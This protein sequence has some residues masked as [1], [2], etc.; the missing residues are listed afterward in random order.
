MATEGERL[1]QSFGAMMKS[2]FLT[3]QL[4]IPEPGPLKMTIVIS[5]SHNGVGS[6]SHMLVSNHRLILRLRSAPCIVLGNKLATCVDRQG[7]SDLFPMTHKVKGHI[8]KN[9]DI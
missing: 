9:H 7:W 5:Q 2:L 6:P 8:N 1:I 4:G 3:L